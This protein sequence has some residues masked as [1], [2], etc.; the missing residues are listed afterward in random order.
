MN[1]KN[2]L[3]GKSFSGLNELFGNSLT[4]DACEDKIVHIPLYQ[5]KPF[6]NHPFKVKD[7]EKMNETVQSIRENGILVP[8][9]VRRRSNDEYELISGHRR[10]RACEIIGLT[11]IPAI[12]KDLS[13]DEATIIMVDANLQREHLDYSEKAFAYKMKFNALKHQGSKGDG[14]TADLLG[15]E[16]GESGRQIR[17][18][19]RLT[20]LI[21][22]LLCLV[23]EKKIGF[24]P[25]VELSYLTQEQ[26][27]MLHRQIVK[28]KLYPSLD[29]CKQL[30]KY[31]KDNQLTIALV[32][33]I[34]CP[35]PKEK[36]LTFSESKIASYFPTGTSIE[37]MEQVI[38]KLLQNWSQ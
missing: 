33:N 22:E 14:E 8:A 20:N 24:V 36:K 10:K 29:Q 5:I 13:D 26:Q 17:R 7:D 11:E 2:I 16:S 32:E 15:S 30:R 9:I 1:N 3:E 18:Y 19:I 38:I 6:R 23:D 28:T 12:V 25:A 34:L 4:D 21:P 37:E 27:N 31:S 35:I